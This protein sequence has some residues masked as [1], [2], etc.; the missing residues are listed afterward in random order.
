M[1]YTVFYLLV[2]ASCILENFGRSRDIRGMTRTQ[3]V[4]RPAAAAICGLATF[5][6]T[7]ILAGLIALALGAAIG[8]NG[9]VIDI[10]LDLLLLL[11]YIF[12]IIAVIC[13]HYWVGHRLIPSDSDDRPDTGTGAQSPGIPPVD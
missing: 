5:V 13:V 4:I 6:A 3:S 12:S 11:G 9:I 8:I 10:S 2:A 7:N 1:L